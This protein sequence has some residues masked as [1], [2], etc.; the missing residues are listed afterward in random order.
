MISWGI[1]FPSWTPQQN[2]KIHMTQS[3]WLKQLPNGCTAGGVQGTARLPDTQ[4]TRPH[5]SDSGSRTGKTCTSME[6]AC[7]SSCPSPHWSASIG[8]RATPALSSYEAHVKP[9]ATADQVGHKAGLCLPHRRRPSTASCCLRGPDP[10]EKRTLGALR[11][12]II[13]LPLKP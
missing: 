10:R 13:I 7:S 3:H 8:Q 2:S 11:V 12:R 4:N 9:A 6:S 5:P 1:T